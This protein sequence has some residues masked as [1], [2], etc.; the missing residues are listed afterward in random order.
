M[1]VCEQVRSQ[2]LYGRRKASW[3]SEGPRAVTADHKEY[4]PGGPAG[5]EAVKEGAREA[6]RDLSRSAYL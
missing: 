1:I 2:Q 5:Q 6:L 4:N 3:P